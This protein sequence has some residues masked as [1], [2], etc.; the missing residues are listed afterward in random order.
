MEK[1][2]DPFYTTKKAGEG[3]GMG[4]SVVHGIVK[5]HGGAITVYSE[6]G[7]GTTFNVLFPRVTGDRKAET[8]L[9]KTIL[10]GKG[11]VLFIDD[12]EILVE[13]ARPMLERLG[14][15]V[16][17]TTDA[18]E[19]LE[20][21]RAHPEAFDLVITDQ[22][23]PQLTGEKL[24]Q[25][26]LRVRPDIPIILCTGYSEMIQEENA[27]ALGIQEFLLKPFSIGEIA[28]RI[29]NVLKK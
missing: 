9:A 6:V 27:K 25:E 20:E 16:T 18:L 10:T 15:S 13:S 8:V 3:T 28:E 2:F 4:L 14:Y 22:T 1:A 7:K 26:L 11:R 12:E 23:M 17:T 24:A 21:F 29:H 5:S 19:A